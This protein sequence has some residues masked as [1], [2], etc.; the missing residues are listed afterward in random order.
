MS[1][2]KFHSCFVMIFFECFTMRESFSQVVYD[3]CF[4]HGQD[5][6]SCSTISNKRKLSLSCHFVPH[7]SSTY[8]LYLDRQLNVKN[9]GTNQGVFFRNICTV[10][11]FP[12]GW[13]RIQGKEML[14]WSSYCGKDENYHQKWQC[15]DFLR[16]SHSFKQ[17]TSSLKWEF[18]ALFQILSYKQCLF[19]HSF[20]LSLLKS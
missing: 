5:W 1:W 3:W 14:L 17:T 15:L 4:P 2:S 9:R 6:S 16:L 10:T 13:R 11:I 20:A 18:L 7:K 12:V 8:T 19:W